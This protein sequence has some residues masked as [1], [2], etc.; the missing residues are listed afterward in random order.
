M[1]YLNKGHTSKQLRQSP[2]FL[3]NAYPS[4]NKWGIPT[5]KKSPIDLTNMRFIGAD[6]TNKNAPKFHS[7]KTIHFFLE[8]NKLDR[9]YKSPK[10]FLSKFAQYRYILTPDYSLYVDMPT[11]LQL[12]NTFRNR[13][14]G[15]VWQD[16]GLIVIPTISWST[17]E[18]F[19]FCFDGIEEGSVVAI[20]TLGSRKEKQ[21]FLNGYFE[22]IKRIQPTNVLCYG[23]PFTEMGNEIIYIDYLNTTGRVK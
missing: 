2:N 9:Y 5:L 8:D 17:N 21:L 13:Y 15:A 7:L 11:A 3:R 1:I 10:S 19:E 12:Y 18:S 4:A 14:C 16:N 23:K 22:M 20:S 6:K